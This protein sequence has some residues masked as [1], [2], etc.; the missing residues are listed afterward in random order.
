[1]IYVEIAFRIKD[2]NVV[3]VGNILV[4]FEIDLQINQNQIKTLIL[5][6]VIIL[7]ISITF[8]IEQFGSNTGLNVRFLF[9]FF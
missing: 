5:L 9:I 8:L 1:M 4:W 3:S 2:K 7:N 6:N